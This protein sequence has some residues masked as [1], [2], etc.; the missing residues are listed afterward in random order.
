MKSLLFSAA[1]LCAF[2][3]PVAAQTAAVD[4]TAQSQSGAISGSQSSSGAV[5]DQ[6]QGQTQGQVAVGTVG[7]SVG[8]SATNQQGVAVSNTFNS[9]N[10]KFTEL[11]TNAAVPLAASSSFSSDFCGA[12]ASG[13]VSAAPIGISIGGAKPVYDANC[14]GLRRAEKFGMA[15]ANAHNM[16][17]HE[18]AGRLMSLMIWSICT[19]DTQTYSEGKADKSHTPSATEQAC[20]KMLLLGSGP[21]PTPTAGQPNP[22]PVPSA[23]VSRNGKPTPEAVSRAT[24][25]KRQQVASLNPAGIP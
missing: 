10:R 8:Q 16:G 21:M 23:A 5:S 14:Q 1:A 19:S 11:N 25:D 6:T 20:S 13:G 22:A 12:T 18:L 9:T 4:A 15:A 7:Q 2:A 3:A 24:D 17:Q